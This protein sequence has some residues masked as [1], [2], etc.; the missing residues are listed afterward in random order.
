[1]IINNNT[2][3]TSNNNNNNILNIKKNPI[4]QDT[5]KEEEISLLIINDIGEII[6]KE[7]SIINTGN[8][9]SK[10]T[11][12]ILEEMNNRFKANEDLG[13]LIEKLKYI[14]LKNIDTKKKCFS[15]WI[16]CFNYLLIYKI[17]KNKLNLSDEKKWKT[18]FNESS[19]NIGGK[20]FSPNDI[21]Y[22]LFNKSYFV[23][24]SYKPQE[25]VKNINIEKIGG[26][27]KLEEKEKRIPFMLYLPIKFFLRPSIYYEENIENEINERIK[28]YLNKCVS[29][30][31]KN[32]LIFS[33][34]LLKF[35]A[36]IFGKEIKK[37]EKFFN[38]QFFEIIK[39]KKYKKTYPQK[40]TWQLN[41]DNLIVDENSDTNNH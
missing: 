38:K 20:N 28:D 7:L 24:S 27:L 30:D 33:D 22:I 35:N 8:L 3:N 13:K 10:N 16:N 11:N 5:M 31:K 6:N 19:F 4:I 17:F 41:F 36:N 26:E 40:T 32:C 2:I 1:M 14:N 29:L 25:Y 12:E 34:I 39:D 37:Y 23:S 21:Q 18:F 15:F 9:L